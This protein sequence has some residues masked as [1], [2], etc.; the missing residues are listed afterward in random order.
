[1]KETKTV[2]T[3][4]GSDS[5]GGA[6]IQADI[7]TI[8]A[9]GLYAA[10]CITAITAQNT[11]KVTA[12]QKVGGNI[13]VNQINAVLEDFTVS[14]IKIGMLHSKEI[15]L[16]IK[17][18]LIKNKYKGFIVLD[19]VLVSTSGC[20]LGTEKLLG[21][22]ERNLFPLSTLITPNIPEAEAILDVEIKD[23]EDMIKAG[24]KI[25]SDFNVKNVLIKGGHLEDNDMIDVLVKENRDVK[26]FSHKK[27]ES[28]NTHGTGCSLSSAIACYLALG[29]DLETS[30]KKAKEYVT[31]AINASKDLN[32]GHGHG[33]LNHFF[34]PNKMIIE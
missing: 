24:K 7:K 3:I 30:I 5:C 11:M 6:G 13:L 32:L 9:L 20:Y 19:P 33:S 2:L 27:I 28:N 26:L 16:Y 1:M 12:L 25:I 22:I 21:S 31:K 23:E 10:S 15:P 29:E 18:A 34:N 17:N 14:A 8:S 4:A